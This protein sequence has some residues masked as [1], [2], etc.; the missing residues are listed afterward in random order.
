LAQ[1]LTKAD[2]PKELETVIKELVE[3]A[4]IKDIKK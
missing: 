4:G 3:F 1:L 2:L